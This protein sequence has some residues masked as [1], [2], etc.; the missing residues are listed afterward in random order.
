MSQHAISYGP[1][2]SHTFNQY[3]AVE[4][5]KS[6]GGYFNYN[7]LHARLMIGGHPFKDEIGDVRKSCPLLFFGLGYNLAETR[8]WEFGAHY[9]RIEAFKSTFSTATDGR[10]Q[11]SYYE[12]HRLTGWKFGA[13]LAFKSFRKFSVKV[14]SGIVGYYNQYSKQNAY[15]PQVKMEKDPERMRDDFYIDLCFEY[16]FGIQ[17]WEVKE[18]ENLVE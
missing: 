14:E 18:K 5:K 8:F 9:D 16:R 10:V 13:H 12:Y 7:G 11:A 17:K 3:T 6:F 4:L 2:I 1:K 15:A